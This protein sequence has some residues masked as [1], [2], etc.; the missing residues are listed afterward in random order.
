MADDN[1]THTM[2]GPTSAQATGKDFKDARGRL[3]L[4][5]GKVVAKDLDVGKADKERRNGDDYPR[6]VDTLTLSSKELAEKLRPRR[7]VGGYEYR[8]EQ[9]D[10]DVAEMILGMRDRDLP[11]TDSY[12][13][14]G[15]SQPQ[16]K[17]IV[18][19]D[20]RQRV[21]NPRVF[22]GSAN[23]YL[24][25]TCTATMIGPSTAAL[26]RALFLPE[27]MD[28]IAQHHVRREHHG[29]D[30]AVRKL[31]SPT[32][33]RCLAPGI[34]RSGTGTSPCWSS[35]RRDPTWDVKP[36]GS[37]PVRTSTAGRR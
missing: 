30:G 33:S 10:H 27:R 7:L 11:T 18:G 16:M 22:P 34:T 3:W 12:A 24:S 20:N 5:T 26:C 8:L 13:G 14:N 37:A 17:F 4:V 15:D 1:S 6:S 9:P 28:P 19:P 23:A 32:A 31:S 2:L 36:A 21:A 25:Q 35:A 29:T